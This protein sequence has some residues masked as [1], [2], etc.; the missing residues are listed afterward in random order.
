MLSNSE[1]GTEYSSDTDSIYVNI[2]SYNPKQERKVLIAFDDLITKQ[3]PKII[4]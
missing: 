1:I 4:I 3:L 2:N